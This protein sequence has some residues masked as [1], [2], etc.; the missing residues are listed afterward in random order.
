MAIQGSVVVS[1]SPAPWRWSWPMNWLPLTLSKALVPASASVA[2]TIVST[3]TASV[4]SAVIFVRTGIPSPR[5]THPDVYRQPTMGG[6]NEEGEDHGGPGA[7]Q[8]G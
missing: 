6:P 2:A 3:A 5:S 8:S 1:F 4:T 7:V